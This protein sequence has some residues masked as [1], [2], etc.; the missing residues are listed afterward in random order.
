MAGVRSYSPC[1]TGVT[2]GRKC[3]ARRA[4]GPSPEGPSW[5]SGE[6]LSQGCP[7]RLGAPGHPEPQAW[8]VGHGGSSGAAPGGCQSALLPRG[9]PRGR[10]EQGASLAPCPC[11]Q[12][13]VGRLT[14]LCQIPSSEHDLTPLPGGSRAPMQALAPNLE[15]SLPEP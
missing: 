12:D 11:R 15:R 13:F 4:S 2:P 10:L 9:S 5:A 1:N 7:A 6:G 3:G 14:E 8:C